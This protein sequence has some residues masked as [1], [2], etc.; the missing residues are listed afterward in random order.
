MTQKL[1]HK[2]RAAMFMEQTLVSGDNIPQQTI[3][4]I[5]RDLQQ[6]FQEVA[7]IAREEALEEA[8]DLAGW[9]GPIEC[10]ANA[11]RALKET[12]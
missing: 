8:A 12:A 10:T 7:L 1:T 6:A 3:D 11:I 4:L 9:M 2:E 5:L